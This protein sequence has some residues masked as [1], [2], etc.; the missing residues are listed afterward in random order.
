VLLFTGHMIDKPG[1]TPARFPKE[2]EDRAPGDPRC[3]CRNRAGPRSR[4]RQDTPANAPILAI[5][6]GACGG[7]LLFHEVCEELS[8]D[9]RIETRLHLALPREQFVATSVQ[10]AGPGWVERF[11]TLCDR[12]K[13]RVLADS[14]ELPRWLRKK[15][16]YTIWSRNNL[17]SLHN[18]LVHGGPKV[19]LIALWDGGTGDGPGGTEDMVRLARARGAKTIHLNTK[20]LFGL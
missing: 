3:G 10:H 20:E 16:D 1:R 19:T 11:N 4:Q 2:R 8:P 9:C 5:A 15:K 12:A 17:W 14:Q 6:G 7:D 18:A 13:P